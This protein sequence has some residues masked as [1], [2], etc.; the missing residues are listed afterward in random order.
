MGAKSEESSHRGRAGLAK[1]RVWAPG[2]GENVYKS[3]LLPKGRLAVK[4]K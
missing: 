2:K 1:M 4:V 3:A